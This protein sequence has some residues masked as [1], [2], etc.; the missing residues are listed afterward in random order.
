[1]PSSATNYLQNLVFTQCRASATSTPA[2]I[3]TGNLTG[4]LDIRGCVFDD[5]QVLGS[6]L[7]GTWNGGGYSNGATINVIHNVFRF[8]TVGRYIMEIDSQTGATV[9]FKNNSITSEWANAL[10]LFAVFN[11]GNVNGTFT[12][13]KNNIYSYP[14]AGALT[15]GTLGGTFTMSNSTTSDPLYVD[16]NNGDFHL[17]TYPTASPLIQAGVIV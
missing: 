7:I 4:T 15:V 1:M 13:N 6:M 16:R 8:K 12:G 17:Q 5:I 14:G 9:T 11:T 2:F 10:T 3:A